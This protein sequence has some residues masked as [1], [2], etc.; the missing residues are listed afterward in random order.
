MGDKY[1]YYILFT[2]DCFNSE[3]QLHDI[4]REFDVV[5][6]LQVNI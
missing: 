4:L 3:N 1:F 5:I 2:H 6:D